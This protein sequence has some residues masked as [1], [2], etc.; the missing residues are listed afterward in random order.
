MRKSIIS[1]LLAAII[2]CSAFI[3]VFATNEVDPHIVKKLSTENITLL[4]TK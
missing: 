1:L 2:V 3:G 4:P